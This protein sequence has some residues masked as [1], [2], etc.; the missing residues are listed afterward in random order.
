MS[1]GFTTTEQAAIAFIKW[2]FPEAKDIFSGPEYE[3]FRSLLQEGKDIAAA[4]EYN[5]LNGNSIAEAHFAIKL[6][7]SLKL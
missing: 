1:F 3:T 5:K 6:A 4:E 2:H 7:E